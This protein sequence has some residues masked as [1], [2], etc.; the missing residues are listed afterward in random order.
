ML[1]DASASDG[2]SS[3]RF[4]HHV[5]EEVRA[6]PHDTFYETILTSKS[7]NTWLHFPLITFFAPL[8]AD[9]LPTRFP[10]ALSAMSSKA[11]YGTSVIHLR[12][13]NWSISS[14]A[15]QCLH[16]F[17]QALCVLSWSCHHQSF[18]LP[19]RHSS[20]HHYRP[21]VFLTAKVLAH[22]L[23]SLRCPEI[24]ANHQRFLSSL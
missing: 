16:I 23:S 20:S 13:S 15:K 2:S 21:V 22:L 5:S 24:F 12:T 1:N 7:S 3:I 18:F 8:R 14:V 17:F 10:C 11:S 9:L 19:F 6:P 4:T